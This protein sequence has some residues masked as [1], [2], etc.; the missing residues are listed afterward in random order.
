M[1][2][3]KYILLI[4]VLT[5]AVSCND[6]PGPEM[7]GDN[8]LRIQTTTRGLTVGTKAPTITLGSDNIYAYPFNLSNESLNGIALS[9]VSISGSEYA[10]SMPEPSQDIIFTN[11][12]EDADYDLV[13]LLD[14]NLMTV[15]YTDSTDGSDTDLVAG[16]LT[17]TQIEENPD[18]T[19]AVHLQRMVAQITINFRVKLNGSDEL[20]SDLSQ[21]FSRLSIS[22][23]TQSTLTLASM[24]P[25]TWSWSGS[26]ISI[27]NCDVIPA[28]SSITLADHR[29]ISPSVDN[30]A[31]NL[32]AVSPTGETLDLTSYLTSPIMPNNHYDLTLTLRQKSPGFDFEVESLIQDTLSADF[33]YADAVVVPTMEL[34]METKSGDQ[35]PFFNIGTDDLYCYSYVPTDTVETTNED[36]YVSEIIYYSLVDG[37]PRIQNSIVDGR[38]SFTLPVGY[39]RLL[40]SNVNFMDGASEYT[41]VRNDYV[42]SNTYD[43]NSPKLY[44]IKLEN[45]GR[46]YASQPLITGSRDYD[47]YIYNETP[48]VIDM[49]LYYRTDAV[50]ILMNIDYDIEVE[51]IDSTMTDLSSVIQY[52]WFTPPFTF[53]E[54]FCPFDRTYYSTNYFSNFE[55]FRKMI[56]GSEI[57]S[58]EY[59]GANYFD[60]TGMGEEMMHLFLYNQY[61]SSFNIRVLTASGESKS[62]YCYNDSST[63]Y[64][65][66]S[67]TYIF[68]I[69]LSSLINE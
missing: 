14:G 1:R 2:G 8:L 31:F 61:V 56:P 13:T 12:S 3:I 16:A 11:I 29:F 21:F 63:S 67:N 37:Y 65:S 59:N 28:E 57:K 4:P 6:R 39:Q 68:T 20:M 45:S 24:D 22:T 69:R 41:M 51:G 44:S 5:L 38:Y 43:F 30:A 25:A 35:E 50:R 64:E 32:H 53:Y 27:W 54:E 9:P 10:Y 17:K 33:D 26:A 15:T 23:T 62:L 55:A 42:T 66:Q 19:Y 52:A 46:P 7:N 40:V 58:I 18:E 60:I 47:T 36:G 34:E 48:N 49:S